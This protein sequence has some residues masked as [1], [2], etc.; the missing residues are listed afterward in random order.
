VKTFEFNPQPKD[1]LFFLGRI[2]PEKG[3]LKAIKAAKLAKKRLLIAA[4]IDPVDKEY[5]QKKV[6]PL[7]DGRQIK[8][9]G[10]VGKKRK[11]QLLKNA[12]ALLAPIQWE[13]PFG[14]FM[15]E[16][17]ACGT[18]VIAFKRGSVPEIVKNGKTGFVVKNIQEMVRAIKK[19][20]Q[21]DRKKCR[22][23]VI[24]KFSVEVMTTGYEKVYYKLLKKKNKC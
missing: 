8:Y 11:V 15:T 18:P 6:K 24:K 3:P 2:S 7:L 20:N 5:F 14:L 1:Y 23:R 19:I 10:E 22:E 9:I 17:M 16:A 21:I 13:E 4:K 12:L